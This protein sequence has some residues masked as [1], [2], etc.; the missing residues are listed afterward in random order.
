MGKQCRGLKIHNV[1]AVM[2]L[3]FIFALLGGVWRASAQDTADVACRT[4][5]SM[6]IKHK[7]SVINLSKRSAG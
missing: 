2:A 6:P 5:D 1:W 3:V 7:L 4:A